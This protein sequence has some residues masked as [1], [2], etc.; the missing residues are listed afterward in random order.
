MWSVRREKNDD[1]IERFW[2]AD[3]GTT[4]GGEEE[5]KKRTSL[6]NRSLHLF[7]TQLAEVLN[8]AG[9]DVQKTL[10]HD[11]EIPWNAVLV[12][13]LIWRPV[14]EAMTDK[15]STTELDRIEPG[16]IYEVLNRHLGNKF[17][18]YVPWPCE[19]NQYSEEKH[20]A[21]QA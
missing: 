16:Q 10:K 4:Q 14:Q 9:L 6:Q 11:I 8:D 20:D 17:G 3:P 7:C 13:E 21:H 12:K 5:V 18:I 2:L 19:E 1:G 15:E